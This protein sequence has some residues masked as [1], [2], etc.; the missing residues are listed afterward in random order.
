MDR[1][2]APTLGGAAVSHPVVSP[3]SPMQDPS[4]AGADSFQRACKQ[5]SR[6]AEIN[7]TAIAVCIENYNDDITDPQSGEV[8]AQSMAFALAQLSQLHIPAC[9]L[10]LDLE[11]ANAAAE[12]QAVEG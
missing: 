4:Q 6:I 3:H 1:G 11:T 9:L 5:L 8:L 10:A 7:A 12:R 2:A